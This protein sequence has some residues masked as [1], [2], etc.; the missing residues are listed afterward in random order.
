MV[1]DSAAKHEGVCL[2]DLLE[3]EPSLHNDLPG[4]LLRF[5]EKPFA[6]SGDVS[7][8]FCHEV[9]FKPED[10]KYHRYLWCDIETNRPSNI[11]EINC[12]VFGDKSSPCQVHFAVIEEEWP[13]AAAV[14]RRDIFVDDLYAYSGSD[15]ESVTLHRDVT[16]VMA[17]GGFPMRK[18]ISS[19]PEV[20]A[21][22]PEAE[23][24][25]PD[26]RLEL[27]ELPAGQA[28]G[29][30]LDPQSDRLGLELAQIDRPPAQNTKRGLLKRLGTLRNHDD[31]GNG[32]VKK[33]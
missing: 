1:F 23:R 24:A 15:A 3:T 14:V 31:D 25:V 21:T 26:E 9:R 17:K 18:W 30:R 11:Y 8:M 5:K 27:G 7:D 32:K 16:A 19:S 6:L 12:P 10:C 4:I 13:N 29:V 2:K 33:Q 20:L 22:V 28:L